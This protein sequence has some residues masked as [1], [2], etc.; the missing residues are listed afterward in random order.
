MK[1][2]VFLLA[3]MYCIV[4][5]IGIEATQTSIDPVDFRIEEQ[6]FQR[7][8]ITISGELF[9]PE[10]TSPMPLVILSHGFGGNR[11]SVRN[12]A[13]FFVEQGIAAY[14][15]DFIGGGNN[16]KSGGKM[17]DMSVLT[18]AKDLM[19]ILDHLKTDERFNAE[20][21]FLFGE[22]QG[23]FI[24]TYVAAERPDEVAGSVLLY[25]A[26]VIHD[27][28][29]RRT[30]DPANIP[31]TMKLL[32]KTIGR[33]YNQDALSFDIYTMMPRYSGKT[34]IIHGTADSTVPLSYS[35]R[36][37]TVFPNAELIKMNGASHGFHGNT[38]RQAAQ[39]AVQFV[40]RII[41]EKNL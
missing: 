25:P 28:A 11:G 41:D 23:G 31:A 32:G 16:I 14:I 9:I 24:S 3:I 35:E 20:Q 34:L 5:M 2:S 21:I 36:A 10:R 33:I 26:F 30:P 6:N 37:V 15:F 22:S 19:I 29:R 27:D 13:K 40:Q 7:N 8:G 17:T 38:M 18:E 39:A 4:S 1:K 12:Y